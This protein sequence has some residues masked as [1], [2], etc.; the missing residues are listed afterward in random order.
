M[1]WIFEEALEAIAW[2]GGDRD[3][4]PC[5]DLIRKIDSRIVRLG[6]FDAVAEL[7][8]IAELEVAA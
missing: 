3:A 5:F 7:E 2:L 1:K 8:R 4:K 6:Y